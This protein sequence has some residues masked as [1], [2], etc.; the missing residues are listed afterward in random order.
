MDILCEENS[1]LSSTPNSLMQLNDDTRHYNNDFNS[2]EANTSDAFN[3][4]IEYEN[5]TN[6][7]CEGCLP[8]TC[9]SLLH[10]QEKN[11]SALLTAVVIILTIAGN[12]LVI[13]AVSLE[14]K[15]QNATNYFLMSLAIA[16]MLLGFLVMPVSMLTILYGL[17]TSTTPPHAQRQNPVGAGGEEGV[18][19]QE[20]RQEGGDRPQPGVSLLLPPPLPPP[21]RRMGGSA[22]ARL[23]RRP[24]APRAQGAGAPPGGSCRAHGW[25]GPESCPQP[26]TG[27]YAYGN[28]RG[29]QQSHQR[30]CPTKLSKLCAVWIYLDV[31]FSTASIMHLCAIS[32]DRYV[33]IQNPI[34][35]S[36]FNSRTKAFLKIIAVW[37]ISVIWKVN[38][39]QDSKGNADI[40]SWW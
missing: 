29:A 17:L 21:P 27:P 22:L 36:R 26:Q 12:I 38:I 34:H 35:H 24:L 16:D 8:P 39:Y 33:A 15:L 19:V 4:T 30:I 11:W 23:G 7:S 2:G 6:L 28:L 5:Q 13:M 32:L 9:F 3:W 31:L 1:S 18:T 10:L 20:P 40:W 37:T 25:L 14:K